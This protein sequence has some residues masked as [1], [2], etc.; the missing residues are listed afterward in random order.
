MALLA[1]GVRLIPWRM[2]FAGGNILFGQ[3]DAYY[4]LRRAT[5]ILKT[6]PRVPGIDMYMAYPYGAESPWPP[7]Y[8]LAIAGLSW[9]IGLGAPGWKTIHGVTTLLPPILAG[10]TVVPV[11]LL[12]RRIGGRGAGYAAAIVSVLVPGHINYSV[13]GSGDHH[14]AETFLLVLFLYLF[15]KSCDGEDG[16]TRIRDAILS[17]TTLGVAVLVWQGSI[18]FGI[19]LAGG[20]FIWWAAEGIR[21]MESASD[22]RTIVA[23]RSALI[24]FGVATVIASSGRAIWPSET[25]Q[26][27]FEFG[28]F[29]WFQPFFLVLLFLL[30]LG[31]YFLHGW[32]R[33]RGKESFLR[34]V[35]LGF[36]GTILVLAI[37]SLFPWF[38]GNVADGIRFLL[39]RNPYLEAINEFQPSFPLSMFHR[40]VTWRLAVDFVYLLTYLVPVSVAVWLFVK[41]WRRGEPLLEISLFAFWTLLA[42][43]LVFGQRRWGNAYAAN[44]AI[45]VGWA[46]GLAYERGR[47]VQDIWSDFL[48]W[49]EA[50]HPDP[51][52][53]AKPSLLSRIAASQKL[54]VAAA[55]AILSFLFIPYYFA[56]YALVLDPPK[57]I[58]PDLYNSLIW[59]RENTPKTK[60]PWNPRERPEYGVL[61]PWDFGHWIQ[62]IS[63]RP[64]V[65]NNYGYQLRGN[66]LEDMLRFFL[67]PDEEGAAAVCEKRNVRYLFLSDIFNSM[68]TLPKLIGIDFPKK[69]MHEEKVPHAEGVMVPLPNDAYLSLPYSRLYLFD[70]SATPSGSAMTRFRLVFESA[71]PLVSFQLPPDTK[72]IKIFERVKGAGLVGRAP[73]GQKVVL[74]ARFSTNFDR[75][76]EYMNI[77]QADEKG[78]FSVR[79]PYPTADASYGI[80][81]ITRGLAY[82]ETTATFFDVREADVMEGREVRVDLMSG[83]P[84]KGHPSVGRMP[85]KGRNN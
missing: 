43:F 21:G 48:R 59:L 72:E 42:A 4:H 20:L 6:F 60:S 63:E 49:R 13:V 17:G 82:T 32:M 55:L 62:Y 44:I 8:D 57:P 83:M 5:I 53:K 31:L 26:T 70:G 73:P 76:F 52:G 7:L 29:S 33:K 85:I 78:R 80:A 16:S 27:R 24:A 69:Y 74:A 46:I 23:F 40:P 67:A 50:K 75:V 14:T 61:S 58:T 28:F 84:A 39:A 30:V 65:V 2:S 38:R 64:T 11:F 35:A 51:A 45:G 71:N 9:L 3:P 54:S 41:K 19:F 34:A 10:L 81:P 22:G 1:L 15:L 37:L 79:F 66:G 25:E 36:G 68:D 12:A 47:K 18:V 56:L 77:V